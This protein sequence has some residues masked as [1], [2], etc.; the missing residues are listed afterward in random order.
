M[1]A[2]ISSSAATWQEE[3]PSAASLP[4]KNLAHRLRRLL[5]QLSAAPGKPIPRACRSK[6]RRATAGWRSCASPSRSSARPSAACMWASAIGLA[7]LAGFVVARLMR[8]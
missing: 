2:D 4:D 6:R 8:R 5:D 3:G 7:A 1:Q